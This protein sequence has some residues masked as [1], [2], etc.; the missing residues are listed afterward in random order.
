MGKERVLQRVI[1]PTNYSILSGQL[2]G[3]QLKYSFH[4]KKRIIPLAN[5]APLHMLSQVQQNCPTEELR[6]ERP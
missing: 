6:R 2:Q 4:I 5:T 1:V 3:K